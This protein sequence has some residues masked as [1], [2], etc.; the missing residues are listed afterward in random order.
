MGRYFSLGIHVDFYKPYV[1]LHFLWFILSVGLNPVVGHVR[2]KHR[3]SC[4][5]MFTD[6]VL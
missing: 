2:D 3:G 5:G 1:D 4:R 6:P